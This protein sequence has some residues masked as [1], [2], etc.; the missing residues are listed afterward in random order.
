MSVAYAITPA[1][2]PVN[3]HA[4]A[5]VGAVAPVPG[6]GCPAITRQRTPRQVRAAKLHAARMRNYRGRKAKDRRGVARDGAVTDVEHESLSESAALLMTL[7]WLP[8]D[9]RGDERDVG[10]ALSA[11]W[12]DALRR[13]GTPRARVAEVLGRLQKR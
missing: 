13:E 11:M 6:L 10:R 2:G 3:H 8:R 9:A 7:G 12:R 4:F 5:A 1:P